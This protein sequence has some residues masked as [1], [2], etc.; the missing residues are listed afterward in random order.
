[1]NIDIRRSIIDNF[2]DNSKDDIYESIEAALQDNDEVT[3]PG[4]GVFFE[5][6]WQSS[7]RQKKEEI[8]NNI[9]NCIK[10]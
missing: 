1:M 2:K 3:L 5:L 9:Y 6:L 10:K 4:L 7:N 8:V